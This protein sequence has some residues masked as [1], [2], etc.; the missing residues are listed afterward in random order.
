MSNSIKKMN[1]MWYKVA[2]D[3]PPIAEDLR[4]YFKEQWVRFYSLPDGK[5]YA[6]TASENVEVLKRYNDLITEFAAEDNIIVILAK[7]NDKLNGHVDNFKDG[8]MQFSYWQTIQPNDSNESYRHLYVC[9]VKWING[10]LDPLLTKV[11]NWEEAGV[12]LTSE[13]STW[14]IAPYDGGI[15]IILDTSQ[16]SDCI[17]DK[18]S[19]WAATG[20]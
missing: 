4:V 14:L 10:A 20:L 7:W 11:A 16:E 2:G 8:D 5:R 6:E 15:D 3:Y 17:K 13:R 12:I 18:Y 9:E 1:E 19:D